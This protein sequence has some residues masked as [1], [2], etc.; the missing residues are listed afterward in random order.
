MNNAAKARGM[1][2]LVRRLEWRGDAR[3][4]RLDPPM[5]V[6]DHEGVL[7]SCEHVVVSAVDVPWSGPETYIFG[8]DADGNV[9]RMS[10]LP[11]SFRGDRDHAR[12]LG[13]A[14]YEVSPALLSAGGES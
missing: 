12:A 9:P 11:G 7:E 2:T 14:G 5:T 4:Y 13:D 3:L 1:A 6:E 8:A 10:E